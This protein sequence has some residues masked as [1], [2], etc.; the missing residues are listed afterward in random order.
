MFGIFKARK[1]RSAAMAV[2]PAFVGY[3]ERRLHANVVSLDVPFVAGFVTIFITQIAQARVLRLPEDILGIV[4]A[5]VWAALLD[6]EPEWTGEQISFQSGRADPVFLFGGANAHYFCRALFSAIGIHE[7]EMLA[8]TFCFEDG[9]GDAY[10][11]Q[12]CSGN[13]R[14]EHLLHEWSNR[15]ESFI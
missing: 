5:E 10:F 4:Q 6:S 3:T 7:L 13:E 1:A 11:K 8:K 15:F 2:V 9:Y 14:R 12:L